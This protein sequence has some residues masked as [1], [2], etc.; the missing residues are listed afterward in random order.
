MLKSKFFFKKKFKE[1]AKF[2]LMA[3]MQHGQLRG[4]STGY[5]D[6]KYLATRSTQTAHCRQEA[7]WA[8]TL[9]LLREQ[10]CL[11]AAASLDSCSRQPSLA[12]ENLG[13]DRLCH[14]SSR[15]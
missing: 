7:K 14:S 11:V 5:P 15:R 13:S 10:L 12:D 1:E 9:I 4:R 2:F 6:H 8:K 3:R